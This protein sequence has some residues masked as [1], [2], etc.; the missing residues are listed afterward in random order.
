MTCGAHLIEEILKYGTI[1]RMFPKALTLML[2]HDRVHKFRRADGWDLV[3][4]TALRGKSADGQNVGPGRR[5]DG[6]CLC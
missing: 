1:C 6:R 4:V 2:R 5:A 3:G